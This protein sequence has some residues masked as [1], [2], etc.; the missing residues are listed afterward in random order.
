MCHKFKNI[1][2]ILLVYCLPLSVFAAKI[3][4]EP[5][6]P[7]EI[8]S[9]AITFERD[10]DSIIYK[11]NVVVINGEKKLLADKI[12]VKRTAAQNIESICATGTPAQFTTIMKDEVTPVHAFATQIDYLPDASLLVLTGKAKIVHQ[13]DIFEGPILKY[14]IDEQKIE[15]AQVQN[16]RPKMIINP[17][18]KG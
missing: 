3:T 5:E 8:T 1:I 10:S 2:C 11:G 12:V 4:S 9:D 16:Q 15:A 18:K 14:R 17:P 13:Q 6:H 7:I